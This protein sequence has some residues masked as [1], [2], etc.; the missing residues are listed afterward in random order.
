MTRIIVS[1]EAQSDLHTIL[2]LIAVKA[3]AAAAARYAFRIDRCLALIACFPAAGPAR[4]ELGLAARICLVAPYII[5]YDAAPD[6]VTLLRILH[7]RR[8]ITHALR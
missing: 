4:P 6:A 8:D 3:G 1:P 5:I 2:A 7:G